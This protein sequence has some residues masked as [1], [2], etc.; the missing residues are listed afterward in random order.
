MTPTEDPH[1]PP[2]PS[3]QCSCT[4]TPR[5]GS[6]NLQ[7]HSQTFDRGTPGRSNRNG[8]ANAG[9]KEW[10]SEGSS[11]RWRRTQPGG[12]APL[13]PLRFVRPTPPR[14]PPQ[15]PTAT[16]SG[17]RSESSCRGRTEE[18]DVADTRFD[19][20][21]G[22]SP[23]HA[24]G[25]PL[26]KRRLHVS[27]PSTPVP[28][29]A[30]PA[31]IGRDPGPVLRA[32]SPVHN[33]ARQGRSERL[34]SK[35]FVDTSEPVR[36]ASRRSRQEASTHVPE[37]ASSSPTRCTAGDVA[38][39][40]PFSAAERRRRLSYVNSVEHG[41]HQNVNAEKAE[42]ESPAQPRPVFVGSVPMSRK[43]CGAMPESSE[44][45]LVCNPSEP[46]PKAAVP[47]SP[48]R[49]RTAGARSNPM[50]EE[51][52][53]PQRPRAR[54]ETM[55]DV[56]IPVDP[57]QRQ[58]TMP[59]VAGVVTPASRLDVAALALLGLFEAEHVVLEVVC[60]IAGLGDPALRKRQLKDLQR[61]LHPDKWPPDQ[62]E[63]A[64]QLF[65]VLQAHHKQ[66]LA[67]KPPV[68]RRKASPAFQLSGFVCH[69]ILIAEGWKHHQ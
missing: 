54:A 27:L 68:R 33:Q 2:T 56:G 50:A 24:L 67:G 53:I 65:Q 8:L 57:Y 41:H 35:M 23:S 39:G 15:Q 16:P 11:P 59:K 7:R 43:R 31:T 21:C 26:R 69:I 64:T 52:H 63:L 48:T 6:K 28:A 38:D 45:P 61:S 46:P 47:P 1:A 51:D 66:A 25:S 22:D 60:D 19:E 13:E 4:S 5:R 9:I 12:S 30:E 3:S 17:Q 42:S 14:T 10:L 29:C 34:R 44:P 18:Q 32:E 55:K 36:P 58:A 62:Q 40:E 49:P 37:P 20:L